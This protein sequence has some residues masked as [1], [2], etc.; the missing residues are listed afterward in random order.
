MRLGRQ[1]AADSSGVLSGLNAAHRL[2]RAGD[3]SWTLRD[4]SAGEAYHPELG[5]QAECRAWLEQPEIEAALSGPEP[6][7]VW[8]V[9]LGAGGVA[10]ALCARLGGRRVHLLSFDR[11][12][13]AL[14][15]VMEERAKFPHLD[16]L[17]DAVWRAR[18][19]EG[20]VVWESLQWDWVAGDIRETLPAAAVKAPRLLVYD[21]HSPRVQPELWGLDFWRRLA[22]LFSEQRVLAAFHTRS[23]AVRST[24]LLAGWH[25]GRGAALGRKEETTLAASAAGMLL[26]PLDRNWLDRVGRS[27][28][29]H[30]LVEGMAGPAPITGEW[31][32]CLQK[33]PQFRGG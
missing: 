10:A 23:T 24:L 2:V 9:G 13:A 20:S 28:T 26:S 12:T 19:G 8:D 21:M 6:F 27:T 3:G 1:F 5:I 22:G 16:V 14:A 7:R 18:L 15:R 30:P 32:E 33:H 11:T 4:E 25:V 29:G 31:M 17:P